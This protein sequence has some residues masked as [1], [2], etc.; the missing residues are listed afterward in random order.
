MSSHPPTQHPFAAINLTAVLRPCDTAAPVSRTPQADAVR[1]A[2]A[3][4]LCTGA[5]FGVDSG[6]PDFRGDHG[7]WRAYPPM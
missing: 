2:D 3:V 6:L 1:A 7:F 5:G 4:I